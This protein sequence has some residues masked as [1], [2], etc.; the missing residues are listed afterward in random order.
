M[1]SRQELHLTQSPSGTWIRLFS[2]AC[3]GLRIFLN[4]AISIEF[5]VSRS[6]RERRSE[7]IISVSG[8]PVK[9]RRPARLGGEPGGGRQRDRHVSL[10]IGQTGPFRSCPQ[11]DMPS[12]LAGNTSVNQDIPAPLR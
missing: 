4:H 3:L 2:T 9:K 10:T 8:G 7:T 6:D 1:I 5:R 11:R 12:Q